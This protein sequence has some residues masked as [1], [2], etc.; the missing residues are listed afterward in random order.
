MQYLLNCLKECLMKQQRIKVTSSFTSWIC[1]CSP[2]KALYELLRIKWFLNHKFKKKFTNLL[3]YIFE[4]LTVHFPTQKE[5][6]VN[7]GRFLECKI[8]NP[9]VYVADRLKKLR[10]SKQLYLVNV[11]IVLKCSALF[12]KKYL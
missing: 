3:T 11:K 5:V 9:L 2:C 6:R 4:H 7:N 8:W 12:L 1:N 10:G